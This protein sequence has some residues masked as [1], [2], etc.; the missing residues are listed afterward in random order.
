MSNDAN[1][2]LCSLA[3][4]DQDDHSEASQPAAAS[5]DESGTE[6]QVMHHCHMGLNVSWS[7]GSRLG[8]FQ[9]QLISDY[10]NDYSEGVMLCVFISLF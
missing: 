8:N 7:P 2:S 6:T 5:D 9:L 4:E 1:V 3:P 10:R